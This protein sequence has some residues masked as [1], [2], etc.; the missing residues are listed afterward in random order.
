MREQKDCP[1][2]EV[3]H[4]CV[5]QLGFSGSRDL[6]PGISDPLRRVWFTEAPT[7]QVA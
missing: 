1:D 6:F 5:I 2:P 4:A 7:V 3:A